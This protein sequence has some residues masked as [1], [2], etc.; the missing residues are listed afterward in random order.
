[1]K[2]VSS[3]PFQVEMNAYQKKRAAERFKWCTRK[4]RFTNPES[5][6]YYDHKEGDKPDA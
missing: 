5:P 6:Y 3:E 1:M 2:K 4:D